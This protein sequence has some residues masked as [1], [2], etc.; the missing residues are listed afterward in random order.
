MNLLIALD[1][2][3]QLTRVYQREKLRKLPK[4]YRYKR[5]YTLDSLLRERS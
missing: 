3:V 4:Y 1:N 5:L 2:K